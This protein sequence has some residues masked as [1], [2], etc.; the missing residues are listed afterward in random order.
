MYAQQLE[1][2]SPPALCYSLLPVQGNQSPKSIIVQPQFNVLISTI[3]PLFCDRA[4]KNRH[5][6][7]SAIQQ[8]ISQY[9][10]NISAF[11]NLYYIAKWKG[12]I[13]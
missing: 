8:V 11:Y 2:Q 5:K 4:C 7:H 12:N 6:L 10:S 13:C 9:W 1:G 3:E